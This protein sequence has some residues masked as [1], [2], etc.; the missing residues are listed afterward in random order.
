[1]ANLSNVCQWIFK[2]LGSRFE[3]MTLRRGHK[4]SIVGHYCVPFAAGR[5]VGPGADRSP[6]ENRFPRTRAA[7]DALQKKKPTRISHFRWLSKI[8]DRLF[9]EHPH[10]TPK[11]TGDCL[12]HCA[13]LNS[14]QPVA[15]LPL[16]LP[17]SVCL[18]VCLLAYCCSLS[19]S[20]YTSI[21]CCLC[22]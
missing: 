3:H 9:S 2:V 11:Q 13:E 5:S 12:T 20:I 21:H 22:L 4:F 15:S 10:R 6:N 18:S 8:F 19:C 17:L 16:V 1:M 14:T 7:M